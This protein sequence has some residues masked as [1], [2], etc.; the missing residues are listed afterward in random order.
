MPAGGLAA[1]GLLG[2]AGD[3]GDGNDRTARLYL[4]LPAWGHHVFDMTAS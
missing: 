2:D 1:R 3:D 4:D